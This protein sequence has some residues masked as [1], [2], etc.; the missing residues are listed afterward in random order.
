MADV[1]I[2]NTTAITIASSASNFSPGALATAAGHQ[3][4][5]IDFGTSRPEEYM[6]RISACFATN[7]TAFGTVDCYM[8]WA[9]AADSSAF[10]AGIS[11]SDTAYTAYGTLSTGIQQLEYAGSLSVSGLSTLQKA[12]VGIIRPKLRYGVFV[13]VNNT[14]QALSTATVASA[15]LTPIKRQIV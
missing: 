7:P 14:S 15:T 4:G 12:D 3:S 11:A 13:I 6:V 2:Y 10:C 8:A 1:L 9:A 5:V